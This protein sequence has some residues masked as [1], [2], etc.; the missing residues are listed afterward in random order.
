MNVFT[1]HLSPLDFV[2]RVLLAVAPVIALT[3]ISWRMGRKGLWLAI[4]WVV[5]VVVATPYVMSNVNMAAKAGRSLLS[6]PEIVLGVVP[7]GAFAGILVSSVAL[8]VAGCSGFGSV[9]APKGMH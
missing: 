7:T 2:I 9:E 4:P 6:A 3:V 5:A 1:V 8:A